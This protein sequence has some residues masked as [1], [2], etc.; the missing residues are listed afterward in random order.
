[1]KRI[2]SV[3]LAFLAVLSPFALAIGAI[4][5][6]PA[7]Y[8]NSF[9][10][11]LVDK[12]E[13]LTEIKEEKIVI[14]GGSSVAF[15]YE[16]ELM[17]KHL[18]M[19]VVNFGVY[20]ALGTKVMMDLSLPQIRKG[21]IV[22]IAP[23]LAQQT[24]SLYYNGEQMLEACE[25]RPSLVFS[26]PPDDLL[27]TLGALYNF[28][29]KKYQRLKDGNI[30]NPDGI[31]HRESFNSYGDISYPREMN[32]LPAG[33]DPNQPIQL[34]SSVVSDEFV[35]YVNKYAQKVRRKGAEIYFAYCPMNEASLQNTEEE[36]LAFAEYLAEKIDITP[37]G[38]IRTF[39][40][41][42]GYFYDTN[43][44]LNDIGKRKHTI[45]VLMALALELGIP[46]SSLEKIPPAPPVEVFDSTYDGADDENMK[47][48]TYKTDDFGIT[49]TGLTEL[50]KTQVT[51]TAPVG[52]AGRKVT[53]FGEGMLDGGI[54]TTFIVPEDSPV[55]RFE[56]NV[57]RG[58]SALAHLVLL[59]S[60]ADAI[61]PPT[62]FAG[63]ASGFLAHVLPGS[64]YDT[65]YFWR[66]RGLTFVFDAEGFH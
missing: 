29:T 32:I 41:E 48:F 14:V 33:F 18:G 56:E 19:P 3:L 50:G 42:A 44:H 64:G 62:S 10:A 51:L 11:S 4:L 61:L 20:A 30:P 59:P 15:G 63:V 34:D 35:D 57:F 16:S 66:E 12:Y 54:A 46:L 37:L 36:E 31:Y 53:I 26:L 58:A 60:D 1:M 17:E 24:L 13:R 28:G 9:T 43:F 21:D 2:V 5:T 38:D 22:I 49:L 47:Y 40:S 7:V 65:S 55:F 23:E 52:F 39:S 6:M 45:E 8:H 25:E 27:K